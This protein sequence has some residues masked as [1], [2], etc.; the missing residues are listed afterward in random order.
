[1]FMRTLHEEQQDEAYPVTTF[2][3]SPGTIDTDMQGEIR[4]SSNRTLNK[5]SGFSNCMKQVR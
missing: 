2:S 5:L 4:K 3:F 1:M